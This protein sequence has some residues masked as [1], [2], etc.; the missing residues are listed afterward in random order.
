MM[1]SKINTLITGAGG[2]GS[3]GREIMKSL[4]YVKKK[5]EIFVTN[6][7]ALSLSLFETKNSFVIPDA[8]SPEYIEKLISICKTNKIDVVIGGSEP[9]IEILSDNLPVFKENNI[10]VLSNPSNVIKLCYDKL[11]I[12]NYLSSKSIRCPKTYNFDINL[13]DK[14]DTFPVIIKPRKGSGS[15]NVFLCHDKD[16][17]VFF[18]NYLKKYGHDPIFQEHVGSSSE[19]YTI[20]TL[21][22]DQGNLSVSVAMK[23]I[24]EGGL[25]TNQISISPYSKKKFVVSSGISQGYFDNFPDLCSFGEKIAKT[26]GADGPINIQCRKDEDGKILV[27]E[28]NPRF[29]GSVASRS[30]IG[31]NEPDILIQYKLNH[32]IPEIN[33]SIPGYVMKDFNEKF[34]SFNDVQKKSSQ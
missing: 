15:R 21:Y 1:N 19:E 25:S 34:I 11:E 7:S 26:I 22:A 29:S 23:R 24:L 3:L 10:N 12:I 28:I 33:K 14:I 4:F 16:E 13:I 32:V 18:G 5:Y 2:A 8:S 6:S 20:G 30:L 9:E 31:H 17:A 27:F